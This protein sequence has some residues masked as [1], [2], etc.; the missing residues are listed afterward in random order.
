VSLW[1]MVKL[2][3]TSDGT[4]SEGNLTDPITDQDWLLGNKNASAIL[5]EYGDYQCPACAAY[6]NFVKQLGV[7]FGDQIGFVYRN[8][9]LRS[10]HPN[11]DISAQA[12]EAAGKQGKFWEMHNMLFEKQKEWEKSLSAKKIFED[13]AVSLGLN[14]E[15]FKI[16]IDSDV[17]KSRVDSGF[18]SAEK[19]NLGST[20]SF[21]LNGKF[22]EAPQSY[23]EFKN[24]INNVGAANPTSTATTTTQ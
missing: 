20:P 16:D 18:A 15:Q 14:L 9:P 23:E 4:T 7:D 19:H 8:F 2:V 22:I 3:G 1:G 13:Y 6:H 11:S 12:A 5:V 24:L 21:F 17:V 10:I